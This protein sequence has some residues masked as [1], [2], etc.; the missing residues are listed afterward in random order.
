MATPDGGNLGSR[1]GLLTGSIR[2]K[3]R[4]ELLENVRDNSVQVLVGTHALLGETVLESMNDLSLVVIDEEQRFGV[5][6]RQ[7]LEQ[8]RNCNIMYTTAT[9]IPRSQALMALNNFTVSTLTTTVS[10]KRPVQTKV[11]DLQN[12]NEEV[13]GLLSK[14]VMHGTKAFWVCPCLLPSN[15]FP[16]SSA[17]ERFG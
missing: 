17:T 11:V 2:G 14:H 10:G 8:Q 16:G 5:A 13:V 3:W 6:Q 1:V 12:V 15:S 4:E 7:V 9:P